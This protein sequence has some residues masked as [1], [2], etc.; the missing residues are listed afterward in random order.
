MADRLTPKENYL[1]MCRGEEIEY[2]PTH[3]MWSEPIYDEVP[4]KTFGCMNRLYADDMKPGAKLFH[5]NWGV[6]YTSVPSANGGFIPVGTHTGKYLIEDIYHWRDYIKEPHFYDDIDW[7]R[8]AQEELSQIDRKRTAVVNGIPVSIFQ[9]LMALMGF[10]EGLINLYEEPELCKEILDFE[11]DYVLPHIEKCFDIYKPDLFYI[12][13]DTATQRAPFMS[14]EMFREMI[15]PYYKKICKKAIDNGVP[16]LYHNCG[17][18]EP[19]LQDMIDLGV[20]YWDPAQP[21]ND[22]HRIQKTFG[23]KYN[24]SIVGA[25]D[26]KEPETWP[27]VSEEYVREQVRQNID[28]YAPYGHFLAAPGII[29]MLGDPLIKQVN[30]WM[31]DESYHYRRAWMKK[32]G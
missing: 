27:E 20:R 1:R 11:V 18:C 23:E 5:D 7:E 21:V 2:I 13:D 6:E 19:Y 30:D 17:L 14:L 32:N 28:E 8:V 16:L 22:L 31:A 10:N 15:L 29:G 4:L 3:N 12:I 9:S 24:F 25:F 26:W